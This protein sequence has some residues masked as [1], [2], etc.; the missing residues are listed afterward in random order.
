[1]VKGVCA[2]ALGAA[3]A[4]AAFCAPVQAGE[5]GVE[6]LQTGRAHAA[7]RYDSDE[8]VIKVRYARIGGVRR[9]QVQ[10]PGGYWRDCG[11]DCSEFYRCQVF[12]FWE[13]K[14]ETAGGRDF[15][16]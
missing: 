11:H 6:V 8:A 13:C 4:A 2:F 14:D 3:V 5:R 16:D 1:M 10:M 15:N 12:D 7:S 9:W